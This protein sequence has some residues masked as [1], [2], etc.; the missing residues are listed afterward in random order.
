MPLLCASSSPLTAV[1]EASAH[2]QQEHARGYAAHRGVTKQQRKLLNADPVPVVETEA[3]IAR[4]Q[5][6]Q[7]TVLR[8]P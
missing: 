2:D 1:G 8:N 5:G 7:S 4:C 6:A 3:D